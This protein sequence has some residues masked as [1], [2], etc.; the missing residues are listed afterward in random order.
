MGTALTES[1]AETRT[2]PAVLS[3]HRKEQQPHDPSALTARRQPTTRPHRPWDD[4]AS[5]YL[6]E[7]SGGCRRTVSKSSRFLRFASSGSWRMIAGLK[8]AL[9]ARPR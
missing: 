3:Q 6:D 9:I 7:T 8:P 2:S 1:D 4:M 5:S